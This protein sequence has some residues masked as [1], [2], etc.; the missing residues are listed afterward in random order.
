M[1]YRASIAQIIPDATTGTAAAT[2]RELS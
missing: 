2:S 1:R